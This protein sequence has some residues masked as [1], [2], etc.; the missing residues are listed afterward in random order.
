[1]GDVKTTVWQEVTQGLGKFLTWGI[2][3]LF[4][5]MAKLAFDSRNQILTRKQVV[6]KTVLSM[7]SGFM[8][9]VICE[10]TGRE[11]WIKIVAPVSTL[12]G[13]SLVVYVMS[14]WNDWA[15]RFLP[16]WFKKKDN[17]LK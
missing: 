13:E 11:N 1:M 4:G 6:I 2:Y 16:T 8:S 15:Y 3:I 10:H 7:F 9:A 14:N 12:L 5:V 17:K